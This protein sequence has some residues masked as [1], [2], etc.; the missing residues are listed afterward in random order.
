M[1]SP[2]KLAV[3]GS[4]I[5]GLSAAWLLSQHHN[6]TVFE[7]EGRLGGHSNTVEA[8]EPDGS[9]VPVD[10]GFIVYN[11]ASYPNL[12]ALFDHLDVPTTDTRMTFAVSMDHGSYEYSG[13]GLSGLFGQPSNL[14]RP[15]HY[16][17]IS[18]VFRFFR[19][20]KKLLVDDKASEISLGA[21]LRSKKFSDAFVDQ[22]I[23]P[24]AAAIWSTPSE[25]ILDFP[26][27][28]FAR[29]FDNHGL[30]QVDQPI[31]RTVAGGSREYVRR[32]RAATQG[33]FETGK[34]VQAIHRFDGGVIVEHSGGSETFDACVMASHADDTLQ[35]LSDADHEERRLLGAFKYVPNHAL[36]HRDAGYMPRRR[37]LWSSWNY[38][39]ETDGDSTALSVTYWMNKLQ[40]LATQNDLFVTLNPTQPIADDQIIAEFNYAHP[41]FDQAAMSAQRELWQLQGRRKTWFCGSY[42][43][44]GFHE[45]GLQSGL[46]VAEQLGG[47]RRPWSVENE[48]GRIHVQEPA[49]SEL[50]YPIAEAAE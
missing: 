1:G 47:A 39:A 9:S 38:L 27:T 28:A 36:L 24:M 18:D 35:L 40:P 8:I 33:Q 22:H 26:A 11:T 49:Q 19:E 42:F 6:V 21:F 13:T 16:Q 5:S 20:A 12:V 17:M 43:G 15:R 25:Q 34:P 45:D 3:V 41:L 46:A 30:L 31:W 4:G 48:S 50:P 7:K 29:F 10:T 2:L 23:L 14:V 44:Y 32:L 37:R